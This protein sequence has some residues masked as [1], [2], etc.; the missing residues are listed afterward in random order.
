[1]NYISLVLT[2]KEAITLGAQLEY[3]ILRGA[4]SADISDVYRKVKAAIGKVEE[5]VHPAVKAG[6]T[7][8]KSEKPLGYDT[9]RVCTRCGEE[10]SGTVVGDGDGTGQRFAHIDCYTRDSA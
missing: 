4:L 6:F 8:V 9:S 2:E 3:D 7:P 10:L 5:P 1:M